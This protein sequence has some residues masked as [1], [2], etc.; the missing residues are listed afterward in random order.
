MS[1]VQIPT[2][3]RHRRERTATG[4]RAVAG[5]VGMVLAWLLLLT[6]VAV[7][8]LAVLVP[9]V[10]GA[11]PYTVLTGSM[12]PDY[13]PGTMVV[14]R[15]VEPD[16]LAIGTVITYQLASGEPTVVTHRVVAVA[17]NAADGQ[18][19]FQ[20]QG[21][22]ND[23]ADEKWVRPEQIRGRLWYAVPHLGQVSRLLTGEQRELGILVVA[24]GLLGYAGAMFVRAARERLH[25]RKA[26]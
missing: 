25:D 8:L 21:D 4:P 14:A 15:P 3:P 11:T 22:A 18:L 26:A 23:T 12:R 13:P 10:G 17:R 7:L 1:T 16:Q 5:F 24:I 19:R 20:T 2:T 9:R 6:A